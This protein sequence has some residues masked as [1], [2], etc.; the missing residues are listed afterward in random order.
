MMRT[1]LEG[2]ELDYILDQDKHDFAW[3]RRVDGP[4]PTATPTPTSIGIDDV[5]SLTSSF[6]R[7]GGTWDTEKVTQYKRDAALVLYAIIICLN[8]LDNELIKDH[9]SVKKK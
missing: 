6:A 7:I 1:H 2:K 4:I 8:D 3:I 5:D 9:D